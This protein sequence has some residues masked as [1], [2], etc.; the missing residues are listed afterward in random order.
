MSHVRQQIREQFATT[1]TGLSTTGSNVFQSRVYN[2]EST[3]LP[4][5]IVYTKEEASQPIVI[6]SSRTLERILSL[7]VEAYVKGISNSDDTIDTI[8]KEIET[9]IAADT[10]LNS[11]A[12]DCF[13]ESTEIN[14]N[15]EG[16]Q[17]IAVMT[18]TYQVMY[19]TAEDSPGTAL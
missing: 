2:L 4:G 10:T 17:P 18:M 7:N 3:N 12:K 16:E 14:Y 8:A 5:L 11:L 1:V 6:G 9:A 19:V 15:G 13:L